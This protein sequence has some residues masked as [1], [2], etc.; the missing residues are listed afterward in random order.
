MGDKLPPPF[1]ASDTRDHVPG[2]VP[3]AKLARQ[4][5]NVDLPPQPLLSL[6]ERLEREKVK[7]RDYCKHGGGMGLYYSC[8]PRE[9][10]AGYWK[11][12]KTPPPPKDPA[13]AKARLYSYLTA[14]GFK[15]A[16]DELYPDVAWCEH[17]GARY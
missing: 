7:F 2:F 15:N 13:A 4:V 9:A 11:D 10:S 14:G 16:G 12:P 17:G 1:L 8:Y 3:P 6:E 5:Q